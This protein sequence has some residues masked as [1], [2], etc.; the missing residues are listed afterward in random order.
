MRTMPT[1]FEGK[2]IHTCKH[3]RWVWCPGIPGNKKCCGSN[4]HDKCPKYLARSTFWKHGK[5][6][7][8]A[9]VGVALA[10]GGGDSGGGG[11]VGDASGDGDGDGGVGSAGVVGGGGAGGAAGRG[12]I[13]I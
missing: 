11:G 9:G 8:R 1:V 7:S 12:G 3:Y 6:T 2:K 10:V 13:D 5:S 4:R